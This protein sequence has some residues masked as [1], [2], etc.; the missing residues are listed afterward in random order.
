MDAV[1]EVADLTARLVAIESVNPAIVP[2][3]SG[4]VAIARFIAEWCANAGL[5]VSAEAVAPG[6][7]NVVAVA[8][9][10]GGGRTLILNG[11]TDTVGV[12]GMEAPFAAR[13][14]GSRLH[15]RGSYDM[16]GGVA[17]CML[18]TVDAARAGLAGDVVLTAVADEE[19]ASLGTAAVAAEF[20]ADAAIVAE[21]S[22]QRVAV[23]HRGFVHG[24]ILVT[25]RAAHGSRPELGVDAIA[26]MGR[27]LTGLE[28]LDRRLRDG[29]P[30]P[31]VGTGS[32]HASLIEGGQE[33]S[34]YP[35]RCA[36][37]VE[38][39]TVPGETV[40]GVQAEL[41]RLVAD[42]RAAGDDFG[43]AARVLLAREPFAID[44]D[45][46]LVQLVRRH[47][48]S[49]LGRETEIA[50]VPYWA[51]SALLSAA[52]IPTVIYGPGGDGAHAETEWVDVEDLARCRAVYVGV[53]RELCG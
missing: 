11:H 30:Q 48:A 2:S 22:E 46:A 41:D 53:A 52:G 6:R 25:G 10:R 24:E 33:F 47:A 29:P 9:G 13:L 21:P 8:R 39:R 35:A 34:S 44:A 51:D 26:R 43:G 12:E 32:L 4:E 16:K 17:A 31:Y 7:T 49:V 50:G 19:H 36:V 14:E 28:A 3:G 45:A 40:A 18:A 23:A 20:A 5:E 42:A 1:R 27:V 15:G 38:R 37:Q